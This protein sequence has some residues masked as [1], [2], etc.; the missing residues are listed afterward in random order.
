MSRRRIPLRT[1]SRFGGGSEMLRIGS[2]IMV[3]FV[4]G[5]M[6]FRARDPDTW[7]W[8]TNEKAETVQA[9][10]E[11]PAQPSDEVVTGPNDTDSEQQADFQDTAQAI[12]DKKPLAAEE[13][14]A[15][16]RLVNWARTQ[17]F[18]ELWKRAANSV[19]FSSLYEHP[20]EH[21]GQLVALKLH[22]KRVLQHPPDA[23][24]P[25][26]PTVYEAWGATDESKTFPYCVLFP[27]D[28]DQ[29]ANADNID[30]E[31]DFAGYFL[32]V[33]EYQDKLGTRR[34]APLLIGRLHWR[35]NAGRV[36]Y[37]ASRESSPWPFL[38][39]AGGAVAL[40]VAHRALRGRKSTD[41]P[42]V[43]STTTPEELEDWLIAAE[44][45]ES[46]DPAKSSAYRA[47]QEE[48]LN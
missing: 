35:T 13:M 22:V 2:L 17:T 32:K 11:L 38:L 19:F 23:T 6:Y 48:R 3:L 8:F 25:D 42:I 16:W 44:S 40:F 41:E 7:R 29:I 18:D 5:M 4:I 47:S 12:T 27:A 46:A 43:T 36:A 26:R 37:A 30:E 15:Y 28:R 9:A 1:S 34:G 24:D 33:M 39:V 20:E 31:A 21:R 10:S 45:P 14:F